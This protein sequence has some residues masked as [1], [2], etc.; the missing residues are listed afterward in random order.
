MKTP[1]IQNISQEVEQQ[2]NHKCSLDSNLQHLKYMLI[3]Y[4]DYI[5]TKDEYSRYSPG[6]ARDISWRIGLD[7]AKEDSNNL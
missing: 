5:L 2:I 1:A 6:S 3:G 4:R 7:M